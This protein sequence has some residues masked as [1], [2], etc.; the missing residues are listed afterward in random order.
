[1]TEYLTPTPEGQDRLRDSK[2]LYLSLK[3]EDSGFDQNAGIIFFFA[4][5]NFFVSQIDPRTGEYVYDD[6][7]AQSIRETLEL[8]LHLPNAEEGDLIFIQMV[9]RIP[10]GGMRQ[11]NLLFRFHD[12]GWEPTRN[13]D[14]RAVDMRPNPQ[15]NENPDPLA[16]LRQLFQPI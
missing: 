16:N 5:G 13:F 3:P 6:E 10:P 14:S 2:N 12:H 4:L 9:N 11:A 1:M 15:T 8:V 7:A